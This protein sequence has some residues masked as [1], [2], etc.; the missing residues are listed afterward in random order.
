MHIM[1]NV[2]AVSAGVAR[3]LALTADNTMWGWGSHL[4][5]QDGEIITAQTRPMHLLDNI[6]AICATNGSHLLAITTSGELLTW[7]SNRYGQ[8][9]NGTVNSSLEFIS[10]LENIW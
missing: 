5:N 10:I 1:N 7:G 4:T 2:I 3:T 6:A 8:L 9:G